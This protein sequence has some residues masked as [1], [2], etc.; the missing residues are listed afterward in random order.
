MWPFFFYILYC[1]VSRHRTACLYKHGLSV[2]KCYHSH[3]YGTTVR[4]RNNSIRVSYTPLYYQCVNLSIIM[5]LRDQSASKIIFLRFQKSNILVAAATSHAELLSSKNLKNLERYSY[6]YVINWCFDDLK[7]LRTAYK[8]GK[9]WETVLS[10][11]SAT[12]LLTHIWVMG[13]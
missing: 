4:D 6:V 9:H 2:S 7:A 10:Q 3:Y 5:R 12:W 1:P 8:Y 13:Q 11:V